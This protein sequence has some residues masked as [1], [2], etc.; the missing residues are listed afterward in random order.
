MCQNILFKKKSP[1][2]ISSVEL[3]LSFYV[4][5]YTNKRLSAISFVSIEIQHGAFFMCLKCV[6]VMHSIIRIYLKT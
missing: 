2:G 4:K 5:L 3:A 1:Y 6:N